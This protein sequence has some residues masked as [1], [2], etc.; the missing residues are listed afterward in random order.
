MA[1]FI[2]SATTLSLEEYY[3]KRI[4]MKLS[5]LAL[6]T[7]L[8]AC[9]S[10]TRDQNTAVG[11]GT[12]AVAG[13]L[14]GSIAKGAGSGWV[15]AA[16]AIVGALIGG[17]IGSS[18]DSTDNTS[19]NNALDNNAINEPSNWTNTQTGSWYKIVPTSEPFTYRGNPNCR[20]YVA[21]AKRHGKTVESR[22]MACR[23]E[24]GMWQQVK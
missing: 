13:G 7:S 8:T 10:N 23:L 15:I 12:G 19:A 17:A 11:A 5:V 18:M 2:I 3:M 1:L 22:G 6:I 9:S 20:N 4:I 16:G 21:Y 14:L 24:N